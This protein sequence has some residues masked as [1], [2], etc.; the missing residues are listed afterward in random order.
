M[1]EKV[2][3]GCKPLDNMLNG[4][5]EKKV[6]TNFYGASGT[7]KTNVCV[8]AVAS[9]IERGGKVVFVDTEGGFSAER[10][11]QMHGSEEGLDQVFLMEIGRAHV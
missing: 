9:C 6:I 10:F 4:G 5:I 1:D 7:G 2:G 8:Q 3:T 11:V